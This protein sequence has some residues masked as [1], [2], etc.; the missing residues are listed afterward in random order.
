MSASDRVG[1]DYALSADRLELRV[2]INSGEE[3]LAMLLDA[4][5][6]DQF[7]S[8][9]ASHRARMADEHPSVLDPG[10]RQ[11]VTVDPKFGV[12]TTGGPPGLR[13]MTVRHPGFG[14]LCFGFPND[15]AL[16]LSGLLLPDLCTEKA[17]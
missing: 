11:A 4:G 7:I 9:L 5:D 16:E 8:T 3:S 17:A 1:V 2:A 10:T 14:W 6:L 13:I 12:V 15:K